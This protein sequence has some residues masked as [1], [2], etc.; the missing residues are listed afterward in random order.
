MSKI[1]YPG[2]SMHKN[3]NFEKFICTGILI[4]EMQLY[5][6]PIGLLNNHKG[7]GFTSNDFKHGCIFDYIDFM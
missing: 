6:W 5:G 3:P 4:Y 7:N 2:G 1:L